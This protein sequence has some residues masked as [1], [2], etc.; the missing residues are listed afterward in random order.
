MIPAINIW[1]KATIAPIKRFPPV[2]VNIIIPIDKLV[3]PTDIKKG[4]FGLE[5]R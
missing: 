4:F 3:N 1:D 2:R 5:A